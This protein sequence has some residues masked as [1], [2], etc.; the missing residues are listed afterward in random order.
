MKLLLMTIVVLS[1]YIANGN[2]TPAHISP[3]AI[4]EFKKTFKNAVNIEWS[5]LGDLSRVRFNYNNE[6]VYAFYNE[7]GERISMGRT[8]SIHQLPLPLQMQFQNIFTD[9][10]VLEV[11]EIYNDNGMSFYISAKSSNK[12]II[13]KSLGMN[14]IVFRKTKIK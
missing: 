11:F 1:S 9:Y 2:S 12:K 7:E 8:I 14:W 3:Q 13:L 5:Q 4:I 10:T 6:T